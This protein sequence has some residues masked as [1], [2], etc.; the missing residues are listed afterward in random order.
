M[1]R[2]TLP[3]LAAAAAL[4][5]GACLAWGH[6]VK[7]S[8]SFVGS[9]STTI[10]GTGWRTRVDGHLDSVEKCIGNRRVKII[11]VFD[12]ERRVVDAGRSSRNGHVLLA[13]EGSTAEG[14]TLESLT[15]KVSRTSFGPN[16]HSH[17]C[18]AHTLRYFS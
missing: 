18:A 14:A 15:F 6:T 8:T 4:A 10:D 16:G 7:H 11:G 3:I 1:H 5:T 9:T 17:V 2:I 12:G 13:D